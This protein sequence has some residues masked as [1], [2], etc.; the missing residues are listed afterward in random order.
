MVPFVACQ[1][2]TG[3]G[4]H[5]ERDIEKQRE[6]KGIQGESVGINDSDQ[7]CVP[8]S[9]VLSVTNHHQQGAATHRLSYCPAPSHC[10]N[11]CP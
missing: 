9:F 1:L 3:G 2:A 11:S 5:R 8:A 6:E 10:N 4:H 7:E